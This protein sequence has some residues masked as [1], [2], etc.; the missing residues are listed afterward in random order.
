MRE[1]MKI[2]TSFTLVVDGASAVYRPG[3][4]QLFVS[5][6]NR[7][8]GPA[9]KA[10][11]SMTKCKQ[12]SED[13]LHDVFLKVWIHR[14]TLH[15]IKDMQAYLKVL[16]R[17]Q[18]INYLRKQ[19][20][21]DLLTKNY[22]LRTGPFSNLYDELHGRE[23]QQ[24]LQLAIQSLSPQRKKAFV[25][26]WL[27]GW[28]RKKIAGQLNISENTVKNLVREARRDIRTYLI[29]HDKGWSS[30]LMNLNSPTILL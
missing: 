17:N 10:V 21:E 11:L 8:K 3:S 1:L 24:I 14:E 12:L 23:T 26:G 22:L 6:Y 27:E 13:I 25:L 9:Y 19:K 2:K 28:N 20:K 16:V 29:N 18:F 7:F 15:E 4:D 30:G 5:I